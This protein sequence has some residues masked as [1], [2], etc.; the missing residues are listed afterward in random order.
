MK[1]Q[2][3]TGLLLALLLMA[4]GCRSSKEEVR[5]FDRKY[6][7]VIR[8]ARKEAFFFLART[9][10]PGS[11]IAVS[12]KGKTIWSEGFGMASTDLEVPA[13]R[14]TKFRIG[15]VTQVLTALCYQQMVENGILHPDSAVQTYLPGFP[16]KREPLLLHHLA[17]HTSGIRPPTDAELFA[18]GYNVSLE[19][20]LEIFSGDTLLFSPG[21][22]Q[23]A[24][25][26]GYN[27]LGAAMEKA[28]GVS[29]PK[30]M[31][32]WVTDT[33]GLEQT[34][35]DNPFITIQNRSN[36]YDYNLVAQV[37][38]APTL[39]LR[40]RMPADGYLST[41]ED[42]LKLG[43]ALLMA[44]H[45]TKS[46]KEKMFTLPEV[47]GEYPP[48]WANGFLFVKEKNGN[49]LFVSRGMSTT[50]GAMLILEPEAG[51]VLAWLANLSDSGEEFPGLKIMNMFRDFTAGRYNRDETPGQEERKQLP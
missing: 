32:S 30:V 2:K 8:D 9:S 51:I 50:S 13:T 26:Y 35:H 3:T 34:V 38:H 25:H 24:S 7:E 46:V 28:A 43:N 41:T 22:Y 11:S 1:T 42:L 45:P 14:Y 10:T 31:K 4:A 12:V 23:H 33:L 6:L 37:I 27:L 15:Q 17:E 20:G 19:K 49:T 47:T 36:F 29:F 40:S 39:D 18:K 48:V 21:M 16:E 44:P 5:V